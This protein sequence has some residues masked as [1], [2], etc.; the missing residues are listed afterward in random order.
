MRAG[1]GHTGRKEGPG[2]DCCWVLRRKWKERASADGRFQL[3]G[4]G[5]SWLR[6]L[7]G[8]EDLSSLRVPQEAGALQGGG[9]SIGELAGG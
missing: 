6:A 4:K 5:E 3:L 8:K 9:L 2:S 1:E 7:K